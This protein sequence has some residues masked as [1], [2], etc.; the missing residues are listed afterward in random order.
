MFFFFIERVCKMLYY[1][2]LIF[3]IVYK[4]DYRVLYNVFVDC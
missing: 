3:V 4:Y 2:K 1:C